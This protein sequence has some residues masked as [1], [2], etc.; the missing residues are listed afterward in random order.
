MELIVLTRRRRIQ[1][2]LHFGTPTIVFLSL[3]VLGIAASS[4]WVGYH[5]QSLVVVDDP[6]PSLYAAALHEEIRQQRLTVDGA[7]RGARRDLDALALQLSE[8]QARAIRIDALGVRLAELAGLDVEEFSFGKPPARGGSAPLR[9]SLPNQSVDLID[10]LHDLARTLESRT[11]ELEALEA[12]L[13]LSHAQEQT[14]LSG[15]PSLNGWISSVF[16][17]RNDP[18]NGARSF[19]HGVDFAGKRGSPIV[20]VA[21]G[22]VA[23]VGTRTG[24]GRVVELDH[25]NGYRTRYAHNLKNE[26]RLGQRVDKGQVIAQLGSSGR[27]TGN[28]VH[29]EVLKNGKHLD[30]M[31]FI[32]AEK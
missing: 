26:V 28:H 6:R 11:Q 22:I 16:G 18:I 13:L 25:G 15:R 12:S 9:E 17:A 7:L 20:A 30:P 3:V 23:F 4:F 19:H 24:L 21:A 27:S 1:R 5:Y 29:F 14:Q 10:A 8:L 2:A 31:T 32:R